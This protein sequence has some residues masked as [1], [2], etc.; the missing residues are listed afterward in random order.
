MTAPVGFDL[1]V[2]ERCGRHA[3]H[4][5]E[6][7]PCEEESVVER[8]GTLDAELERRLELV[9]L[10]EYEGEQLR[11]RDYAWLF[12]ATIALPIVLMIAGW[13]A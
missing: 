7:K 13:L 12:A 4:W 3:G 10:P 11:S 6:G 9:M 2:P 8:S 1:R 5:A